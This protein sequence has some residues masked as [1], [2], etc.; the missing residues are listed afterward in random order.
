[1]RSI[2]NSVKRLTGLWLLVMAPP[3]SAAAYELDTHRALSKEAFDASGIATTLQRDY[4]IYPQDTFQGRLSAF[5]FARHTPADWI[6]KG[7]RDEDSP[8]SRV[9]NHFYD[10]YHDEPLSFPGATRAPDWALEDRDEFVSSPQDYSYKDARDAL[11]R[12]LTATD[13]STHERELGHTFY[14]LGH[15]IHLIQ[16]MA[17]PQHTRN[18]SHFL[19][20]PT[21]SL[22]ERYVNDNVDRFTLTASPPPC[23]ATGP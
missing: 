2:G 21:A 10:P 16:D 15:V 12:G 5:N 18:D 9:L 3:M 6:A 7:G 4:G 17:Q 19:I 11:Y 23:S 8:W 22:M 1:M 13:S 20:G 14:A